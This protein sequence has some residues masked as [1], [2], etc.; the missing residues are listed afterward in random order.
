MGIFDRL[1]AGLTK[2]RSALTDRVAAILRR[3]AIDAG[4]YE[5]LEETLLAADVGVNAAAAILEQVQKEARRAGLETADQLLPLLQAAIVGIVG[6]EPV[7][8]RLADSGPTVILVVGVNGAGKTTTV[9]KLAHQFAGQGKRTLVAAG[10]TFRAAAI[11]QL[12]IWAERAGVDI[13]RQ[14]MGSDAAAV[15]FDAILAA[16]SRRTDILLCDTAGRLQNKAHLMQELGKVCRVIGREL[17]GAPHEVLLVLDATTGQNGV[18]QA[19][20]FLEAAHVTGIVLTKLDSTAK[21][22]VVIGIA[23]ELGI[24]VKMVGVGEGIDDLMPFSPG[25]YARALLTAGR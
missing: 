7:P 10:D 19:R 8:L 9:G 5:E 21:G 12:Q 24:P 22:G 4:V 25:E 16:R 23:R 14:E 6:E 3:R 18:A 20:V 15:I 17:P 1:K 13:V 11:E 2:T